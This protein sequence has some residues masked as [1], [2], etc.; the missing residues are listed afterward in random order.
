MLAAVGLPV[1]VHFCAA[2]SIWSKAFFGSS[3]LLL[4]LIWAAMRPVTTG[5]ANDVPLHCARY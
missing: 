4:P 5:V 2:A 1:P 3:R